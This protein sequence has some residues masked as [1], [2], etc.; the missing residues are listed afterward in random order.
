MSAVVD[1]LGRPLETL[2]VSI[3]DRCNFRCVYC[4]PKEVFGRDH[5]FLDRKELLSFEEIRRVVGVFAGLGVKRVRITGGEPL[6]RRN[7]EELVR[8][9]AEIPDLDLAL[10][11]NGASLG[12]IADELARAGL[13]RVNVSLDSLRS[14]R[15]EAITQRDAL[16]AVLDGIDAAV[17]AGLA[18]VKVN[19]VVMR[20]VNDDEIVDFA[21]FGRERGVEVRFI[22][23]MPL[24]AQQGWDRDQVVTQDEIVQAIDAVYPVAPMPTRGNEPAERFR[25]LDGRGQV[26]VIASVTHAFCSS[27]D[28]V[29]LTAEGQLATCLFAVDEHDLRGP[30]RAGASDDE[31]ASRISAAVATKW[32]GHSIDKVEFIR[33][34]RSMSQ[35]GG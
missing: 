13:R 3:T 27:C 8:L 11:T 7:V 4:M 5:A 31:L 2:R 18:P 20:D 33:P 1:R 22:E 28:R 9:L 19:V 10:T 30:L 24:D 29:R 34:R 16:P 17:A 23:V 32:A 26:G 25:Y 15:F 35:I 14:G 6:V 21:T 12:L